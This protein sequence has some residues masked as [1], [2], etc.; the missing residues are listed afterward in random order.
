MAVKVGIQLYSVRN[1]LQEKPYEALE[2]VAEIGYKYVEAANHDALFDYGCGFDEPADKVKKKLDDIG[3][4]IVGCHINPLMEDT[5]DDV[6][7]YHCELGNKQ[8]GCDI[9]FFPYNDIDYIKRRCESF[10]KIGEVCKKHGMRFYYHNHYQEWQDCGDDFIY[11]IIM[12]NTDPG[13][14]F[15]EL[16]TYWAARGGQNPVEIMKKYKDRII[17]LHQKD[18]PEN[19]GE[20]MMMFNGL[21][22]PQKSI[23]Y[24][25]FG[26]TKN[27]DAFTE[28]GYGVLPIQSYIFAAERCPNLDY[29]ILEQDHT[30]LDELE[31]IKTSMEGFKQFKGVD[32]E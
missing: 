8:I 17:L 18:F 22:D 2:K 4:Q 24:K 30:K 27:P 16:D 21:V 25:T 10:N 32:F 14:V 28:I 20:T 23:N 19:A 6:L 11:D 5:I 1:S 9:E 3:M 7:E 13:L 26:D 15:I 12:D 29:I 31:S